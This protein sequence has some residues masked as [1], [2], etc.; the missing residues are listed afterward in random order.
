MLCIAAIDLR[1]CAA[2]RSGPGQSNQQW[3]LTNVNGYYRVRNV[4]AGLCLDDYNL[5]TALNS[6]IRLWTCTG[7]DNQDWSLIDQ[8]NGWFSFQNRH[9]GLCMD[10]YNW[11]N[12]NGAR[13]SQY[14]CSGNAVQ[15]FKMTQ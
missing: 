9:S 10:N 1:R 6:D 2:S 13:L 5:A 12:G 7:N 4:N 8:G 3:E 14:T 11:D 15:L